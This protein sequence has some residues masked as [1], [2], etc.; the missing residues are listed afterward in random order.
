MGH[1]SFWKEINNTFYLIVSIIL[2]LVGLIGNSITF[3]ISSRPK[4]RNIPLFRY[5]M[6]SMVNDFFVLLTMWT[7]TFPNVFYSVSINCKVF[8]FFGILF[9][10]CTGYIIVLSLIDQF[11]SV[12][13]PLK[14]HFRKKLKYQLLAL[15]IIFMVLAILDVPYIADYN[16]YFYDN[17]STCKTVNAHVNF[18]ISIVNTVQAQ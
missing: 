9:N 16:I 4:M 8:N 15:I 12:K 14:F 6:A 1:I 17:E 2:T 3:Y 13:Y 11:L 18:Y 7:W 5:L 10:N